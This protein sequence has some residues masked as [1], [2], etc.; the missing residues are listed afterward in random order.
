M[1]FQ[2]Q[3]TWFFDPDPLGEVAGPGLAEIRPKPTK[4]EIII[5]PGGLTATKS[6]IALVGVRLGQRDTGGGDMEEGMGSPA[7][8]LRLARVEQ[9][10]K[11]NKKTRLGREALF[12]G[13][14]W[15]ADTLSIFWVGTP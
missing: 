10:N 15:L 3:Y 11:K 1:F 4:T 8:E 2:V 12:R 5:C 13:R 6:S 9:K 7:G 14:F